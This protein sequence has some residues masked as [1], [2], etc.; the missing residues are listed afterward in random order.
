MQTQQVFQLPILTQQD[1]FY[2]LKFPKKQCVFCKSNQGVKK[3]KLV[4]FH[5]FK[6][7]CCSECLNK[8]GG[9]ENTIYWIE[10]NLSYPIEMCAY[11]QNIEKGRESALRF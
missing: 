8:F 2:Y 1:F 10:S 5:R 9:K 11:Y 3:F 4:V 6:I 7:K